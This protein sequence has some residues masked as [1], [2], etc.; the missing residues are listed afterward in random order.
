MSGKG[1]LCGGPVED[2]TSALVSGSSSS[3]EFLNL[4]ASGAAFEGSGTKRLANVVFRSW[5]VGI[6]VNVLSMLLGL[7]LTPRRS[8]LWD[9]DTLVSYEVLLSVADR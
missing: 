1:T 6:H 3:C 2:R 7:V 9:G 4:L 5:P 8:R